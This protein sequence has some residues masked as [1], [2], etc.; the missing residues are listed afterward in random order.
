MANRIAK[1]LGT[2]IVR[3]YAAAIVLVVLWTGYTAAA[4]LV[5][6]VFYPVHVPPGFLDWQGRLDASAL[7]AEHV[8]GVGGPAARAPL[9]H[10]H[11]V[12]AWFQPDSHS[13]CSTSGCHS[14]VPHRKN[15]AVRAFANLHATFLDCRMCHT[16]PSTLPAPAAWV[17]FDSGLRQDP[18]AILRL[19]GELE[20][21]AEKIEKEPAA[22]HATIRD[23]LH[24]AV[25]I[26]GDATLERL[27]LEIDTAEPGSP[28]WRHAV[29]Q[30]AVELPAYSRGEYR[31]KLAGPPG[32]AERRGASQ[33]ML[34]QA[35]QW[36][37]APENSP[38]RK[39]LYD[40]MHANLVVK[41]SACLSCHGG[42]PPRLDF[43]SVG[44]SAKRAAELR[45]VATAGLMQ[46]IQDGKTFHLPLTPGGGNAR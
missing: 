5:R 36:L 23:L 44:Y 16:T 46:H 11:G 33:R 10:Y 34:D 12:D 35:R 39:Q 2:I 20:R 3:A 7:R 27:W 30:L 17:S 26:S 22:V 14:P 13:D 31:A 25:R 1:L 29:G 18:P 4:Y 6:F 41:P 8:P 24:E 37:A 15:K 9:G 43:E 21:N 28:V 19:A 32:D 40:A 38:Q 45:G 42:Q